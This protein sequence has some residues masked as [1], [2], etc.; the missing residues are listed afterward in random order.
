MPVNESWEIRICLNYVFREAG[1]V[2]EDGALI[3]GSSTVKILEG[4]IF[5]SLAR[6]IFI[7]SNYSLV[8]WANMLLTRWKLGPSFL[9]TLQEVRKGRYI[10]LIK[11]QKDCSNISE[12]SVTI[13]SMFNY[14][15]N[16]SLQDFPGHN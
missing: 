10:I 7:E 15:N 16:H 6:S 5:N 8:Y 12:T 13:L 2:K 4:Q 3:S 9:S 14:Y 11:Y 1:E